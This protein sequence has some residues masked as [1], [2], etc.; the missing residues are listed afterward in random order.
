M[1]VSSQGF[2]HGGC[3]V[4]LKNLVASATLDPRSKLRGRIKQEEHEEKPKKATW[5]QFRHYAKEISV[6]HGLLEQLLAEFE[7][8][9][10]HRLVKTLK[11]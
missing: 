2:V 7:E 3:S 8:E 1:V 6:T 10:H 4:S 5:E 9:A 11:H